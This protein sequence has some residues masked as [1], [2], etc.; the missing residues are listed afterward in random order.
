MNSTA[1]LPT[2]FTQ[3]TLENEGPLGTEKGVFLESTLK[4]TGF[5]KKR[6]SK[7]PAPVIIPPRSP[8]LNVPSPIT[9]AKSDSFLELP[10][11]KTPQ[12]PTKKF[13]L[14]PISAISAAFQ[15]TNIKGRK[16]PTATSFLKFQKTNNN[17][18]SPK[19]TSP[20]AVPPQS[21]KSPKSPKF[22]HRKGSNSSIRKHS[23]NPT[24]S[25][26]TSSNVT[27]TNNSKPG[28]FFGKSFS[29]SSIQS[30]APK[31]PSKLGKFNLKPQKSP[32]F[33]K[34]AL[35][36]LPSELAERLRESSSRS[37]K[38]EDACLHRFSKPILI[39]V[40]NLALYQDKHIRESFNVNLPT[41][42]IKRYRRG[43]MSNF[44]LDSFITTPE[45]RKKYLSIVNEDG[46][47]Y[48][49]DV[50]IFDDSMDET[51]KDSPGWTLLSVLE[52]IMLSFHSSPS[53]DNVQETNDVPRGRVYWLK[54][55]FEAF[56]LW[57]QENEF[58]ATGLEVDSPSDK[59]SLND[60]LTEYEGQEQQQQQ[61]GSGLVRRDSLFSVNTERNS[62]R[63]KRSGKQPEPKQEQNSQ[64][65]PLETNARTKHIEVSRG[66]RPSNG[67]QYLFP[68]T[69]GNGKISESLSLYPTSSRGLH[70]TIISNCEN[71]PVSPSTPTFVVH[72]EIAFVVSTIIPE[73][74]FIGPEI[75]TEE[76]VEALKNKG[77]RRILNMAFECEDFLG[78]KE[79][80]DRYLKLNVKDSVEED[81]E[82]FLNIA[83]DFIE[84]AQEDKAPVYVHCKA[85]RS[86]SVTAVLAYLIKS[87]QWTLRQAYDYVMEHRSGIC[88]NIGFVTELMRIEE[89]VF[90]FKR[91]SGAV[92]EFDLR[93]KGEMFDME[94]IEPLSETPRTAFF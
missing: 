40:R 11:P 93:K 67:L 54:G 25:P 70:D 1:S 89:S 68:P 46:D 84:R 42:L 71:V 69:N 41:L 8:I 17:L 52:R 77:V 2:S 49:H 14:K 66:R 28:F 59:D 90:G 60:I 5:R 74:L 43:N 73:F 62:L 31:S 44:S 24:V 33:C 86:R 88:P 81:V 72:P 27:Q 83:V 36:I 85:G 80:F 26:V 21:P 7:I 19:S 53:S 61:Q 38:V 79:K 20:K 30:A 55:G 3:P 35:P 51:D 63:H 82:K 16:S 78:L 56:R 57:D 18:K 48:H 92:T 22:L 39:D 47:Q 34:K 23:E 37:A 6:F 15:R 10:S 76:E 29:L 9:S 45:G 12:S 65:P 13:I 64:P 94:Y 4:M 50:I 91:N 32:T 87:H 75:T 58:I